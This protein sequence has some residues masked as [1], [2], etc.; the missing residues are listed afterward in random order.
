M[1]QIEWTKPNGTTVSTNDHDDPISYCE[2]QGWTRDKPADAKPRGRPRKVV[3]QD[4]E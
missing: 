3:E 2:A 4:D 1:T